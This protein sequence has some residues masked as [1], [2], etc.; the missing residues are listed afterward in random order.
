M[1]CLLDEHCKLK[2]RQ[3]A[4]AG[5][6][7]VLLSFRGASAQTVES[8]DVAPNVAPMCW[9]PAALAAKDAEQRIQKRVPQA[10]VPAPTGHLAEFSPRSEHG[11]V[12]RVQ[13][14]LGKKMVA[15]TF[16]LCEQ[17]NEVSGYQGGIVDFL[18]ANQIK[19]TFFAG[20][21][22][23]LTHPERAKQL[24]VDSLFEVG[25]HTWDHRNLRL[26][27]GRAL[28]DEVQGA[29]L[30]YERLR[31]DLKQCTWPDRSTLAD[32]RA[33]KRLQI[34][35]FPFGAC[36]AKSLDT[37]ANAGLLGIQWDVSSGDPSFGLAPERMARDVLGRVQP[38]S[39]VLFH[40]NG[41]GWHTQSALPAIVAGLKARGYQFA[42]V[43]ELLAAG[44]PVLATSCY[45]ARPGDTDRY[46]RWPRLLESQYRTFVN[47][48]AVRPPTR[49]THAGPK[50]R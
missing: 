7:L 30:A 42:T 9:A 22:W 18:R 6:A 36:D 39:I 20:G 17:A 43:S 19:A 16:D 37:V 26:T 45:D 46:D 5:L 38:G 48:A 44:E 31:G 13:L 23:M 33:G 47:A 1:Q 29:Q 49:S 8:H 3:V 14:P 34:F 40:A 24:M 27:A 4:F 2:L 28:S 11:V 25:N 15:L 41:R 35:R 10:F 32:E 21:K 50:A 12:R